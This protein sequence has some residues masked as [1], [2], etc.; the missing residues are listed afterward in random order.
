MAAVDAIFRALVGRYGP[1]GSLWAERPELPRIPIRA[2][3]VFNETNRN[4]VLSTVPVDWGID[5]RA[6]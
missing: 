6:G 4:E 3:Q 1:A 5:G 2:W